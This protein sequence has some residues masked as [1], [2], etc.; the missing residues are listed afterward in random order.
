ML[1]RGRDVLCYLSIQALQTGDNDIDGS[2]L[3]VLQYC[4]GI[5]EH[6][7]QHGKSNGNCVDVKGYGS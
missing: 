3:L 1:F 7:M 4:I 5:V 6:E 2:V